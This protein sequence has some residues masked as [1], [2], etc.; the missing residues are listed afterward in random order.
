Q[1]AFDNGELRVRD[2]VVVPAPRSAAT[3]RRELADY[4]GMISE[5]DTQIGRV[6]D[7]LKKSGKL[8]RTIVVF[9][10]DNGLAMG[11]HGLMGKQ[12][13]YDHSIKV[14]LVVW[15]P[16]VPAGERN[17]GLCYLYDINPTLSELLGMEPAATVTG[18][19]LA[20][21]LRR[22]AKG[23]TSRDRLWLAYSSIHRAL[24]MDGMKYIVYNVD[25]KIT[26][27]L[28][29]LRRDPWE[30]TDL[31]A[32]SPSKKIQKLKERYRTALKEEMRR[33]HDF[34]DLDRPSGAHRSW[35]EKDEKISWTDGVNL[36]K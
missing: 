18:R 3:V 4:Y 17:E 25:G 31:L 9:A 1:H 36:V 13:L 16:G 35:W 26:E 34:C 24:V 7:A 6:I 14:P 10:G 30:M 33:G 22:G 19:S 11:Q 8:E 23:R 5:V 21:A 27:Q 20:P 28:F 2:E 12:S 32:G 29:D 15:A